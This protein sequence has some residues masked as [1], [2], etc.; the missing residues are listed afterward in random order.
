MDKVELI[1]ENLPPE[2]NTADVRKLMVRYGLNLSA[3]FD[4]LLL[5][6][7]SKI[8]D[9]PLKKEGRSLVLYKGRETVLE[10][11]NHERR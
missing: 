6:A 1:Y 5:R 2:A 4:S 7:L 10:G 8:Y 11:M 3:N 9:R